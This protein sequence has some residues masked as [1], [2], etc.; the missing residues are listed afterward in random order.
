MK[1][2]LAKVWPVKLLD[3]LYQAVPVKRRDYRTGALTTAVIALALLLGWMV[4]RVGWS[5][6]VNHPEAQLSITPEEAQAAAQAT[7]QISPQ[8][9]SP[10]SQLASQPASQVSTVSEQPATSETGPSELKASG[11][12][13]AIPEIV[14]PSAKSVSKPNSEAVR[15]GGGLVVY[16]QGKGRI[17]RGANRQVITCV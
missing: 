7:G 4:G 14:T 2:G 5:M 12:K 3:Q 16:D 17:P 9:S 13:P 8:V 11:T 6:A 1:A 10:V 15:S